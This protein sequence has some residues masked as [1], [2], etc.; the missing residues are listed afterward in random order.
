MVPLFLR[1]KV[2]DL[3]AVKLEETKIER[4]RRGSLKRVAFEAEGRMPS[5]F[6]AASAKLHSR[7]CVLPL[8][9]SVGDADPV[10]ILEAGQNSH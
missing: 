1:P 9:G 2:R 4:R 10:S 5:L 3:P 7:D 6:K 8:A